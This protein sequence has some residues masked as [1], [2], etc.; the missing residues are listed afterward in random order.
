MSKNEKLKHCIG[1]RNNFYNGNNNMEI[2]ECW[3]LKSAKL[4]LKKEVGVDQ[5]PPWKQKPRR[6]LSCYHKQKYVYVEPNV[7]Y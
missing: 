5:R 6:V 7:E 2:K 3:S 1:C 4:V